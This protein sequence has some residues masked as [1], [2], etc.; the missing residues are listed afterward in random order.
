MRR[1][2]ALLLA[3]LTG[4]AAE[5]A[6]PPPPLPIVEPTTIPVALAALDVE[7][8]DVF[9]VMVEAGELLGWPLELV[10]PEQESGAVT[11]LLAHAYSRAAGYALVTD[12]CRRGVWAEPY[13]HVVAHELGHALGL[14]HTNV[15]GNL[16]FPVAFVENREVTAEQRET[17]RSELVELA[18]CPK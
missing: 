13:G 15:L 1:A 12:G 5:L 16:M 11:V 4:C 2:R 18:N 9:P 10:D 6:G 8:K 7:D 3:L 14:R 17:M